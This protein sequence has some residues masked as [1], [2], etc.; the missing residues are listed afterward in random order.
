MN[1][2]QESVGELSMHDMFKPASVHTTPAVFSLA[3]AIVLH[4]DSAHMIPE[5]F[6]E[7]AKQQRYN[8]G[9]FCGNI[10]KQSFY[11]SAQGL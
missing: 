10:K 1:F 6:C 2:H 11:S 5:L 9:L 7:C 8:I 3:K 4:W